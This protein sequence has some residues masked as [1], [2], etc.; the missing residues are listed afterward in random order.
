MQGKELQTTLQHMFADFPVTVR[1]GKGYVE[2]CHQDV[3]KG[4]MAVRV[5][6][7]HAAPGGPLHQC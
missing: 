5:N 2:A 3:N 4:A 6:A 1:T 7:S